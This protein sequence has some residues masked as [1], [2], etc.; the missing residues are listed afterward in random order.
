MGTRAVCPLGNNVMLWEIIFG[1][2]LLQADKTADL[3]MT[4]KRMRPVWGFNMH[5]I[6]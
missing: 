5:E 2:Y 3:F 6:D 4:L 1:G